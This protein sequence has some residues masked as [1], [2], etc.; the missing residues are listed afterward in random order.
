MFRRSSETAASSISSR[1]CGSLRPFLSVAPTALGVPPRRNDTLRREYV[2]IYIYIYVYIVPLLTPPHDQMKPCLR[3]CSGT[4]G[5][6][7]A[8][9]PSPAPRRSFCF[10]L[11]VWLS[12]CF[13]G[14]AKRNCGLIFRQVRLISPAL[15]AWENFLGAAGTVPK[16]GTQ[17]WRNKAEFS[18]GAQ[19][20]H[21]RRT[22]QICKKR[23]PFWHSQLSAGLTPL[24]RRFHQAQRLYALNRLCLKPRGPKP[25][26]VVERFKSAQAIGRKNPFWSSLLPTK[27]QSCAPKTAVGRSLAS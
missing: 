15:Q 6:P 10:S 27:R 8:A 19:A 22:V 17:D 24:V 23:N 5:I 1:P 9:P 4:F 16:K 26:I 21:R 7:G 12:E 25:T 14:E 3:Q 13:G 20:D 18:M 2:H 11:S